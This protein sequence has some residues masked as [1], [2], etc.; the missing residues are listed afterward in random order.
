[1]DDRVTRIGEHAAGVRPAWAIR[2]LAEPPADPADRQSWQQRAGAIGAYRELYGYDAQ[3]DE[4]GP[5]PGRHSPEAWADWHAAFAAM[6]RID[7]IDLRGV[8]DGYLRLRCASYQRELAWAPPYVAEELRLARLQARTAEENT[9]HADQAARTCP[10]REAADR[11]RRLAEVWSALHAKATSVAGTLAAAQE[12]RR[13]WAA[14][15]EPTRRM[16]VAADLELRRRHPDADIAPLSPPADSPAIQSA[17]QPK[18]PE[19]ESIRPFGPSI[20]KLI[21]LPAAELSER[22]ERITTK[23]RQAQDTIDYLRGLPRYA[24]D[25]HAV[26]LGPAWDILARR[27][28]DAIIQPPRPEITPAAAIAH[29]AP[30]RA[31]PAEFEAEPS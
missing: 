13:Q 11:H 4:I 7:G 12:T 23:A 5:E 31:R 26:Y 1:M 29:P 3:A 16:A 17:Q 6:E 10:D 19:G 18:T 14:L 15:T 22:L 8:S 25:D 28:R 21:D 20:Q 27:Q 24:A 2:A 30:Q 9:I